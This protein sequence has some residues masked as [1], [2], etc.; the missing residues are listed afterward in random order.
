MIIQNQNKFRFR[1]QDTLY[2]NSDGKKV[3]G[4]TGVEQGK[5]RD[6]GKGKQKIK[7]TAVLKK[8]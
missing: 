6:I 1:Y 5:S 3:S 4:K 7:E 8:E 2:Y